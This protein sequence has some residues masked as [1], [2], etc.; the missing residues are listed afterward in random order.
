MNVYDDAHSLATSI[1][2]SDEFKEYEKI[3]KQIDEKPELSKMIKD[4]SEK[5]MEMQLK[6]MAGEELTEEFT[7]QIQD[8]YAIVMQDP[9]ASNFMQAQLR[10]SVMMKDVY[11]IIQEASTPVK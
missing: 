6:Q 9:L 2:N 3:A 1:K 4:F 11:D 10:F 5:S 8:L 7:K